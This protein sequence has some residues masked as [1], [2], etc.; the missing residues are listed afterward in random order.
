MK[1]T[2]LIPLLFVIAIMLYGGIHRSDT[3]PQHQ[4]EAL[5]P[6]RIHSFSLRDSYD[7][8]GEP[9]PMHRQDIVERLDRELLVNTFWH[10]STILNIKRANKY[11]PIIEPILAANGVPDDFKFLCVA[12]SGLSNAV[13]PAGAKGFWQ[14]LS[15]TAESYGLEV[16]DHVDERFHLKKATQAAC[17]YLLEARDVFGNWT[18]A[19][20]SYNMGM[21]G[22]KKN[23]DQQS[24]RDYYDLN[25]NAETMR[26]IF[27]IVAIKELLSH[28]EHFGFHIN[29]EHRYRNLDEFYTLQI[30]SSIHDLSAFALK[31]GA[32]YRELKYFNPWLYSHKLPNYNKKKYEIRIPKR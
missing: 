6:Q 3:I 29:N 25:V 9:L 12:E 4:L 13:S 24:A 16:N 23:M 7:F 20:A 30:D 22:V 15:A 11:F 17:E 31:Y 5:D 28:P 10:S 27:R 1:S 26:Y 18:L 21:A 8:A 14:F 19:A 32:G 2:T